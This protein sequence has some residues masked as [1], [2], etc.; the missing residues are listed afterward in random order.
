MV[1]FKVK[2]DSIASFY[3]SQL[4]MF[5]LTG[6]VCTN[7]G[8]SWAQLGPDKRTQLHFGVLT[9]NNFI[10][11][12]KLL[13]IYVSTHTQYRSLENVIKYFVS[14]NEIFNLKSMFKQVVMVFL[15][16]TPQYWS[17][18][19]PLI[20][21]MFVSIPSL[22]SLV[23]MQFVS[24][25]LSVFSWCLGVAE[26][27]VL[28]KLDSSSWNSLSVCSNFIGLNCHKVQKLKAYQHFSIGA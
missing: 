6:K 14:K 18:L 20:C 21:L 2:K 4:W 26:L 19:R 11:P 8:A 7:N 22:G 25:L 13:L 28:S 24:V 1:E 3:T 10:H 12:L 17:N 23:W 27:V 15:H 5:N 16:L 9:F